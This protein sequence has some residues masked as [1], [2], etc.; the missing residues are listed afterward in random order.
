MAHRRRRFVPSSAGSHFDLVSTGEGG[1]SIQPRTERRIGCEPGG[2]L[3]QDKKDN[4]G[5]IVRRMCVTELPQAS[6]MNQPN[7]PADQFRKRRL[8]SGLNELPQELPF[9]IAHHGY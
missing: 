8:G 1:N 4:L 2:A 7:I 3:R 9:I 5:Y 6:A